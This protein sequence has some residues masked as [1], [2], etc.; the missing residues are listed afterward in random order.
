[1]REASPV[2]DTR[3]LSIDM[4]SKRR[5]SKA[6]LRDRKRQGEVTRGEAKRPRNGERCMT[7]AG[8]TVDFIHGG[9]TSAS[10]PPRLAWAMSTALARAGDGG[11]PGWR[12]VRAT[13]GG[14][15][16]GHGALPDRRRLRRAPLRCMTGLR[17][18]ALWRP[19]LRGASL[20]GRCL[21][22]S[23]LRGWRRRLDSAL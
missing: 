23:T 2:R 8:T 3:I 15:G 18:P 9:S 7:A 6:D 22:R 20:R 14:A 4:K 12:R 11:V 19:C 1:M 16:A 10:G 17:W 21:R 5:P 13:R